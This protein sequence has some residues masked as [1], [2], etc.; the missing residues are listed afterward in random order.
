M[1]PGHAKQTTVVGKVR[2]PNFGW[3]PNSGQVYCIFWIGIG[4]DL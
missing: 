4:L 1:R 3:V 2:S